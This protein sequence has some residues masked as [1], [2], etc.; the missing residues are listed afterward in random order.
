MER[1]GPAPECQAQEN[2]D[3]EEQPE[4]APAGLS[5]ELPD[6]R[7]AKVENCFSTFLP[8]HLLHSTLSASAAEDTKVSKIV[9]HSL[10]RYSYM[11]IGSTPVLAEPLFN[12]SMNISTARPGVKPALPPAG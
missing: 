9:L 7:L 8:P 1:A 12:I 10:Q 5:P 4:K 3:L 11:G 2:P 6:N